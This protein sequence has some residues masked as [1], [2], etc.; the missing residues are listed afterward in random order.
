M[1]LKF[2]YFLFTFLQ[3]EAVAPVLVRSHVANDATSKKGPP[4]YSALCAVSRDD[5]RYL[6]EWIEYH[7]LC[8]GACMDAPVA[9]A[10]W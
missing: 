4:G 2:L 8:L 5:N 3:I 6:R 10:V 9:V 1:L 7:T